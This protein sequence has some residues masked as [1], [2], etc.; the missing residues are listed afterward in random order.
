[1]TKDLS[2]PSLGTSLP[3]ALDDIVA[4]L[5]EFPAELKEVEREKSDDS[6]AESLSKAPRVTTRRTDP[7]DDK[8]RF[9]ST[10]P[11]KDELKRQVR[12]V[13]GVPMKLTSTQ[14]D[15]KY[16]ASGCC[17]KLVQHPKFEEA[18]LVAIFCNAVWMS[19]D[20]DLRSGEMTPS[21]HWAHHVVEHAFCFIF[22]CEWF[23]RWYALTR[24]KH[25]ILDPWLAADTLLVSLNVLDMWILGALIALGVFDFN[26]N[27]GVNAI[28]ILRVL[29]LCRLSRLVRVFRYVPELLCLGK[30]MLAATRGVFSLLLMLLTTIYCFAIVLRQLSAGT[31]MGARHFSSTPEAMYT[32]MLRGA[33]LDNVSILMSDVIKEDL[34]CACVVGLVILLA[35]ITMMNMLIGILCE[36][37][38]TIAAVE[39][40]TLSVEYLKVALSKRFT[41]Y[42]E[43]GDDS[44]SQMQFRHLMEDELAVQALLRGGVD[45]DRMIEFA[46]FYF[47]NDAALFLTSQEG[48]GGEVML[49]FEEFMALVLKMRGHNTATVTDVVDLQHYIN[50]ENTKSTILMAR[51][52]ERLDIL[53]STFDDVT[54]SHPVALLPAPK[55][56]PVHYRSPKTKAERVDLAIQE[57]SLVTDPEET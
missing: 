16:K 12:Q 44:I 31:Q 55:A 11:D 29:R 15:E 8:W 42:G 30:G 49:G 41:E 24:K 50:C 37:M 27:S 14:K 28:R 4:E 10:F 5:D 21:Q 1:V 45:T 52:E 6:A 26:R 46:D 19:I 20:I 57:S 35:A 39:K 56:E 32:L 22:V 9:R 53:Q 43:E 54:G 7:N 23:I 3:V 48:E 13:G 36:V 40:E 47:R 38:S 25:M 17:S 34:I 33:L 51:L 2:R 18:M